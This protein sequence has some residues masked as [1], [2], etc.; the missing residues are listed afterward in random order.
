MKKIFISIAFVLS[1]LVNGQ[2][3]FA[4]NYDPDIQPTD[5]IQYFKPVGGN[6]FVGDCIPFYKDGTYYLYW[7]LDEGH[8]SALNGLGGHQWSMVREHEYGFEALDA[9]P[10]RDRHR[11]GMGEVHLHGFG[12]V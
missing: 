6:Q 2:A 8:H 3:Q 1:G 12:R 4:V 7:L 10:H 11:R 9:S 5:N